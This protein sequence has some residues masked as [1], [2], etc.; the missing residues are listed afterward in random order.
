MLL[1]P[2]WMRVE[3]CSQTGKFIYV[4]GFILNLFLCI[5]SMKS[6]CTY[7]VQFTCTFVTFL[8]TSWEIWELWVHRVSALVLARKSG[9]IFSTVHWDFKVSFLLTL[10]SHQENTDNQLLVRVNYPKN[11][12]V[13]AVSVLRII[14]PSS[15]LQQC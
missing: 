11:N 15:E 4:L 6:I 5:I 2:L 14:T 9:L 10:A 12:T 3:L 8:L 1:V 7:Q 13:L